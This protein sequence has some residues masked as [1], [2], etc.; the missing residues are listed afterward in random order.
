MFLHIHKHLIDQIDLITILQEFIADV[1]F[2]ER[3]LYSGTVTY[4]ITT[5]RSYS[6]IRILDPYF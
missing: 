2:L 6:V 4:V 1:T 3:S 5:E